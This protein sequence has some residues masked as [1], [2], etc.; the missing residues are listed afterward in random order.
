MTRSPS[1][2]KGKRPHSI[3]PV[4]AAG[5]RRLKQTDMRVLMAIGHYANKAGVCWP[6][7]PTIREIT[8]VDTGNVSR[9]VQNLIDHGFIRKLEPGGFGQKPGVWGMSNRYQVLW[10]GDEPVPQWE[11]V[12]DAEVMRVAVDGYHIEEGS[13]ARGVAEQPEQHTR[14][15]AAYAAAIEQLTGHRPLNVRAAPLAGREPAAIL[16][17]AR[18]ELR[19]LGRVPTPAEVAFVCG[20][21]DAER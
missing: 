6:S 4:R 21:R 1:D 13:G 3:I 18:Q 7:M 10:E 20:Q 14:E 2:T 9:A 11:E 5:D 16:E 15:A 19:R 12:L 8:G 17:A